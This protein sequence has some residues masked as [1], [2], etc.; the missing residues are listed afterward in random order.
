[1]RQTLLYARQRPQN[2]G[3]IM[4]R[5]EQLTYEYPGKRA[6]ESVSFSIADGSITALVGPNGAGKTTLLRCIAA[7]DEPLSGR[8]IV[9]GIDVSDHPRLVHRQLGYL[10][11]SFGLYGD[12]TVRQCLIFSARL[13]QI[14]EDACEAAVQKIVVLLELAPYLGQKASTLSRGW[15][16]RLGI[17]QAIIHTPRLLLLDEPASGLD[18]EARASLSV[19]F[20]RLRDEGM[21]MLV[22]SHILAELEDYCTDMLVLREGRI[23]EQRVTTAGVQDRNI[24]HLTL[25]G[26]TSSLAPMLSAQQ[27]VSDVTLQGRKARLTFSGDDA[28]RHRLLKQL[29]ES[30]VQICDFAVQQETLQDIYL[31]LP[32]HQKDA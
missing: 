3:N 1:M 26:D 22:S 2:N 32:T 10:S 5:V 8:I 15:R 31:S 30:G 18:P 25:L 12:L 14:A 9:A 6:L 29:I 24:I 19:L 28:A 11:D 27:A 21:T 20:R 17:A 7:L 23:T 13:H 16:Q 4:I